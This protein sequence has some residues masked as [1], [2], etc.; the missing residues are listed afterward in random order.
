MMERAGAT[1]IV[2]VEANTRAYLKCLITKEIL[3]LNRA[4]FLCGDFVEHLRINRPR[5]D[6]C[7]ASGVL[8]HMTNPVELLS[9]IARAADRVCLWTQY[10]DEQLLANRPQLIKQFGEHIPNTFEGFAHTEHRRYY[11]TEGL[12]WQ[13]FCGGTK[14]SSCWLSR[15]DI[16]GALRHFGLKNLEI[17][18]D[19]PEHQNGPSMC[20]TATRK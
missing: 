9:L 7:L 8:Y 3:G 2:A 10:Y 4:H 1:S 15:Q 20:L 18:F 14:P 17:G 11:E 13:G 12:G 16:M 5:V 19:E 6:V